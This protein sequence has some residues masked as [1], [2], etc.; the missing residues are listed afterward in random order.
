MGRKVFFL[1]FIVSFPYLIFSQY[2]STPQLLFPHVSTAPDVSSRAVVLIDAWTGTLLY[3]KNPNEEIPPAS[4]TKLMTMHLLMKE[5]EAGR[6]SYDEIIPVT[7]ESWAQSQPPRSSLMFLAPGQIVT[8]REIM[9]G[10]SISSGND[11]AVAAALRLAPSMRDFADLMTMESRRMGLSVTRFVESSGISEYNFTTAA[12][13]AHFCRQYLTLYPQSLKDFHS[14]LHFAYPMAHNVAEA[15]R[16]NPRTIAQDNRN[17]LLRTFSGV[18]G[19]K[20]GYIDESGYNIALTAQ[21]DQTRFIAVILGANSTRGRDTDGSRLLTWAFDNFKTVRPVVGPLESVRLWKGRADSV[22]L[23]A[24]GSAD[25]T[26]PAERA[27]KLNFETVFHGPLIAPLSAGA[28][29]GYLVI[30]DE[31]GELNRVPLLTAGAYGRGNI[32]KR[33]WHSVV[34]YFQT[35]KKA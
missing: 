17:N 11:A 9:L 32:F 21:R 13:F 1:F 30:S 20:T 23:V 16:N 15:Y 5:I 28:A 24:S 3:S 8:L 25:F 6:A 4:L 10:L 12:E 14:V 2:F 7:V 29:V 34:L 22:M 35:L 33:M 18:D 19:L 27:N 31:Y 26:S